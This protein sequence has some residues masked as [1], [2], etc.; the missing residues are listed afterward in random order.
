M[1]SYVVSD[2]SL[3]A[4]ADAIRAKTGGT[5]DLAFPADFVSEIGSI[6]TGGG[7]WAEFTAAS[8]AS[9]TGAAF[10]LL[11][12]N[13]ET[14]AQCV[15]AAVIKNKASADFPNN[16]VV[17]LQ[18]FKNGYLTTQQ[19]IRY[20]SGSYSAAAIANNYDGVVEI[21]DTFDLLEVSYEVL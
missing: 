9:S 7:V 21:G 1:A 5:A 6:E 8:S 11:F 18:R 13:A 19:A 4:V 17:V 2:T 10:N 14:K 15:W 12:P 3:T 20:R 16:Q